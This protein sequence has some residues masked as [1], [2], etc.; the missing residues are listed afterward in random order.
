MASSFAVTT[1]TGSIN[2]GSGRQSSVSYTVTNRRG[3]PCRGRVSVAALEGAQQDWFWIPGE[4]ERRFEAGETLQ[5]PVE[6]RI[7][8]NAQPGT[9]ALRLDVVA[10][11]NPD[12][13]YAQGPAVAFAVFTASEPIPDEP[14]GYLRAIIGTAIGAFTGLAVGVILAIIV[15]VI[16]AAIADDVDD[17]FGALVVTILLFIPGPLIGA[18][19]GSWLALRMGDYARARRTGLFM[20]GIFPVWAL[21]HFLLIAQLSDRIDGVVLALMVLIFVA[22][23]WIVLPAI[24]SRFAALRIGG[25]RRAGTTSDQPAST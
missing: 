1:T 13:D 25:P 10:E 20:A 11:D 22:P 4:I 6:I 19:A 8:A 24:F 15:G 23:S 16:L 17:L 21:L 2:I 3:E 7:P 14:A 5:F 9:Y 18:A 12:E